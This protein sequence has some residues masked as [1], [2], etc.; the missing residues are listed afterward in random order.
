MI[1][2]KR[3][4]TLSLSLCACFSQWSVQAVLGGEVVSCLYFP[5]GLLLLSP[6]LLKWS[7][8]KIKPYKAW[9]VQS[10]L[11]SVCA[12]LFLFQLERENLTSSVKWNKTRLS[13]T[14]DVQ[15]IWMLPYFPFCRWWCWTRCSSDP[16]PPA[17]R[18]RYHKDQSGHS[19]LQSHSMSGK[20]CWSC[21]WQPHKRGLIDLESHCI[22]CWCQLPSHMLH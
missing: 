5:T 2:N 8:T 12:F 17:T 14:W 19:W 11:D 3:K 1:W 20:S 16:G 6:F 22:Y 18:G 4:R 7:N 21:R 15:R 13:A 10:L 9:R